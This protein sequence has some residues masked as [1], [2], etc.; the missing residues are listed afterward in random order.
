MRPP[1]VSYARSGD[2]AIA[3]QAVG[4]GPRDVVFVRGLFGDLLSTWEQPLLVRHV[5]GLARNGRVVML[6]R[7]GTGL[8]DR[9]RQVPSVE[10]AMDDIRAVMDDA[11]SDEAVIWT[12]ATGASVA[13]LFAA[14]YPDRVSG[15]VLFDPL[16]C[17]TAKPDYPWAMSETQWRERLAAIRAHWGDRAFLEE[18]A[19]AWAPEVADDEAFVD[20]LV[21]HLR[22]SLS[23]GAALTMHRFQAELDVRDVLRAVRVPSLVLGHSERP[24]QSCYVAERI[25]GC[26]MVGLPPLQGGFTWVDDDCH[27]A[28]MDA[29]ARFVAGLRTPSEP[30]RMLATVLFTDVVG[31]TELAA[32]LGDAK[33]RELLGRH[34]SLVRR[35]LARFS[36]QEI[37]TAGDGFFATFDGP[38]RA[39]QAALAIVAGLDEIGISVRAGLHTGEFEV[40]DGKPA[41]LGVSVGA[42]IAGAASAGEVLVSRTVR[43]LVAGSDIRFEERGVHQLKGVPGDWTLYAAQAPEHA[44]RSGSNAT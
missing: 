28:T 11:G 36:G 27:E 21:W 3:Y 1:D 25:P 18:E 20:W 39:V 12:G 33:W 4:A 7:R 24:A 42:R 10:N 8:S 38:G 22:R 40:M 30:E 9:V 2:V 6:D 35:T 16:V 13:A 43:D 31:S 34:H 15:L 26:Q 19:R 32:R 5:D 17:G 44:P 14:T 29:T 23:P 41:G 37:D